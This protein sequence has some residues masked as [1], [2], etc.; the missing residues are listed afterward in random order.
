M[1][2]DLNNSKQTEL[3]H[4][5]TQTTQNIFLTGRA[6]TGKSTLLRY[7]LKNVQKNIVALSPTG[8]A[9]LNIGGSTIHSFFQFPLSFLTPQDSRLDLIRYNQNKRSIIKKINLIVIDEVSMCRA[10]IM[11]AIDYC[12]RRVCKS[13][14]PFAGKQLLLV[15]DLFQL[16]PVVTSKEKQLLQQFYKSAYFFSAQVF[17][18]YS[19]KKIT[20]EKVYR[21]K[22]L[23]FIDLLDR[24]RV[25]QISH[26]DLDLLN[27]RYQAPLKESQNKIL[28]T[29]LKQTSDIINT[30]KLLSLP[31]PIHFFKGVTN[32]VFPNSILPV[33]I[34]L[35]LKIDS[36]VMFIKNDKLKRWVNGTI[37]VVKNI[38][39]KDIFILCHDSQEE[40]KVSWE[41]WENEQYMV[42]DEE[43]IES[44]VI[45]TYKQYPLQLAWAI[46][47]HKSQGLSFDQVEIDLGVGSFSAGQTYVALSRCRSFGGL[48]LK[49]KIQFKDLIVQNEVLEYI[50]ELYLEELDSSL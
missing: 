36:Q 29:T 33:P 41:T 7:I 28:V 24:I 37:G 49:T 22:D 34:T 17:Q 35:Q 48:S 32:G 21:Q 43:Q 15:G 12:L 27:S 9:A 30:K 23:D 47:I 42:N 20:L 13:N 8:L 16:E 26:N 1:N 31:H 6:G 19:L 3:L 44:K 50:G 14:L 5:V 25:K 10:D 18:N 40:V 4:N 2:I 46:T 11:D 38:I 39:G 45:G